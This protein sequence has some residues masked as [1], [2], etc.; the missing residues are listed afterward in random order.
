[1][2]GLLQKKRK[3]RRIEQG[4]NQST[5]KER[6]LDDR[7]LPQGTQPMGRLMDQ[8]RSTSPERRLSL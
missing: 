6:D 7:N 3:G 5:A 4:K 8:Q 2:R 1:M